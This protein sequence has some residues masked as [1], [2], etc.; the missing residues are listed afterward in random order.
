MP[1][2]G[3]A[4]LDVAATSH[5]VVHAYESAASVVEL[6]YKVHR[7]IKESFWNKV[8]SLSSSG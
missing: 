8:F 7:S 5:E 6:F 1:M 3:R 2:M 4:S